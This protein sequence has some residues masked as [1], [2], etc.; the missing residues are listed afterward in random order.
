ML[1]EPSVKH[2]AGCPLT[3]SEVLSALEQVVFNHASPLAPLFS[4]EKMIGITSLL[5]DETTM[6]EVMMGYMPLLKLVD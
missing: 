1:M 5:T 3:L 4:P 2:C 6:R